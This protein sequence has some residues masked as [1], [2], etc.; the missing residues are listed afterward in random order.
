MQN[1][2]ITYIGLN[3]C[4]L[5][6]PDPAKRNTG[7][8]VSVVNQSKSILGF[9]FDKLI[10]LYDGEKYY[11]AGLEIAEYLKKSYT[12]LQI[13]FLETLSA[14][15]ISHD[16]V[17]P[18]MYSSVIKI[19]NANPDSRFFIS[20]TSGTPTMHACWI[21]LVKGGVIDA[22]LLQTSNQSGLQKINLEID[23][24]PQISKISDIKAQL[25]YLKREN[26]FLK[27]RKL[28][29]EIPE[30]S[31]SSAAI[32]NVKKQ[33]EQL[34]KFNIPVLIL[35]ESGTGK[36]V[37]ARALHSH[38][39]RKNKP[40]IAINCG[41]ISENLVESELFGHTK[42]SF[43]GAA[44]DADGAFKRADGGTIFLDEIGDLPLFMQ[45]KLLRVLQE[46]KFSKVGDLG[47]EIAV[48]VRVISATNKDLWQLMKDEAFREDLFFR[49]TDEIIELPPLSKRGNDVLEIAQIILGT[50]NT[51]YNK[52]MVFSSEAL[53]K[54]RNYSCPGNIRELGQVIR[55]A[56]IY[57]DKKIL[58]DD[59]R[60]MTNL[61]QSKNARE[62]TA[63]GVN[64]PQ[65]LDE[66]ELDYI[67]KALVLAEGNQTK[68]EKLLSLGAKTLIKRLE[69]FPELKL[70]ANQRK[71]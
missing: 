5:H 51:E 30:I 68:A 28:T 43:T 9:D 48:D 24:F 71:K 25:T 70:L 58:P 31:G 14:D 69:K 44:N 47:K 62:L 54:I 29:I 22:E 2:L 37:A 59:I 7:A 6:H 53:T 67:R 57:A 12:N 13:E 18:A 50:L 38:S 52:K 27:H 3:D 36:E 11:H 65:I 26:D 4:N 23:D 16:L 10:L 17:Y 42:G 39:D 34:A 61:Q 55:R 46:K 21:F 56:F 20:V 60:F 15:P 32:L 49:I 8:V 63:T 45:V 19:K 35:G 41:A 66:T 64:L 33:I 40:F 1:T